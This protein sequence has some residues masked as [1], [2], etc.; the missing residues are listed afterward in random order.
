MQACSST[1]Q[2]TSDL[3]LRLTS[4]L[5]FFFFKA[6]CHR[7]QSGAWSLFH[8]R[9]VADRYSQADEEGA[10]ISTAVAIAAAE[11]QAATCPTVRGRARRAEAGALR[12]SP[13]DCAVNS[14]SLAG[15][16]GS[17]SLGF[18][19]CQMGAVPAS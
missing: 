5:Y 18:L 2:Y 7:G 13:P 15:R 8:E 6:K 16:S 3:F 17:W 9:T 12:A 4:S 19:V 1:S 11:R 14:L 10:G